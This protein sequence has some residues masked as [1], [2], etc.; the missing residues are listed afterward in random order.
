M[1]T[2]GSHLAAHGSLPPPD[3][4]IDSKKGNRR[5]EFFLSCFFFAFSGP[6]EMSCLLVIFN[7]RIYI[8]EPNP[9]DKKNL[10]HKSRAENLGEI[11]QR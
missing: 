1:R 2:G 6:C 7:A 3:V 4:S 10:K 5:K 8:F 11:C 9:Y